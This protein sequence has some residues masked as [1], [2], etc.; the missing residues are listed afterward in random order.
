[1]HARAL[2]PGPGL[3]PGS[4]TQQDASAA[5]GVSEYGNED[6]EDED[7]TQDPNQDLPR[8]ELRAHS[9]AAAGA[10]L[11]A[12][13]TA[14]L[15]SAGLGATDGALTDGGATTAAAAAAAG[16]TQRA[17]HTTQQSDQEQAQARERAAREAEAAAAAEA[18]AREHER[19]REAKRQEREREREQYRAQLAL[20]MERVAALE[21][22]WRAARQADASA[23]EARAGKVDSLAA[24]C[25]KVSGEM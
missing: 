24:V 11:L 20:L 2:T 8:E 6:E 13:R 18:A 21:A 14:P 25:D 7:L 16:E 17:Q 3:Q 15:P 23:A 12:T 9:T 10:A 19:E 22:E 1:M 4:S 5:Q